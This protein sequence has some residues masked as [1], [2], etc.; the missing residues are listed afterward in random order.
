MAQE[1]LRGMYQGLWATILK[2]VLVLASY[3]QSVVAVRLTEGLS[4]V[5][6][7]GSAVDKPRPALH[8]V[9]RVP[10]AC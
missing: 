3:N 1:G 2:Q 6:F 4:Y 9:Q 8:V 5:T 10:E 7:Y